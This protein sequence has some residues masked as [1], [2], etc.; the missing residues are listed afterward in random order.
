M[1]EVTLARRA[2]RSG[3]TP[4]VA[5]LETSGL[6]VVN[7]G[8]A[9]IPVVLA[10]ASQSSAKRMNFRFAI[11]DGRLHAS[12]PELCHLKS[13]MF[14]LLDMNIARTRMN[15]EQ[16]T[17]ATHLSVDRFMCVPDPSLHRHLDGRS[18]V[19][20]SGTGRNVGIECSV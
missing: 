12:R 20:R 18:H 2:R 7:G 1:V 5:C 6:S 10:V 4:G 13:A 9:L 3:T 17:A 14:H 15:A 8:I 16:G 19:N 11:S